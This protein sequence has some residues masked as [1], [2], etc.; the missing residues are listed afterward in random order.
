MGSRSKQNIKGQPKRF[1]IM[2]YKAALRHAVRIVV[3]IS[4]Y[5]CWLEAREISLTQVPHFNK[6][7]VLN[8]REATPC[9]TQ[10]KNVIGPSMNLNE[11][12]AHKRKAGQVYGVPLSGL[13]LAKP[14]VFP[15]LRPCGEDFRKK[16]IEVYLCIV[17]SA[18]S[19]FCL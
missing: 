3:S 1:P 14:G 8:C 9:L 7:I 13:Q 11:S 16:W 12:H 4:C 15:E 2:R 19:L 5:I 10:L 18:P 17:S 6:T